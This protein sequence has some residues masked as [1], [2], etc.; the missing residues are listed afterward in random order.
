MRP[1]AILFGFLCLSVLVPTA[2]TWA[3]DGQRKGFVLGFDVGPGVAHIRSHA[4]S[5]MD[6]LTHGALSLNTTI[7]YAPSNKLQLFFYHRMTI[8][9][10]GE[11]GQAY[12]DWFEEISNETFKGI[13]YLLV[14]PFVVPFLP[15]KA[16]H[17]AGGLGFS[18]F[19]DETAP[20]FFFSGGIGWSIIADPYLKDLLST[21]NDTMGGIGV[22]AGVGYEFR[23][24]VSAE[25]QFIYGTSDR[26]AW[27]D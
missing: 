17:S 1:R 18:G 10:L 20:S 19:V 26:G 11:L 23:P 16:S 2:S 21:P 6:Q 8:F 9:K 15:V 7:G 13:G 22:V 14:T 3:F 12:D 27:S 24:H 25:M 5:R 4:D